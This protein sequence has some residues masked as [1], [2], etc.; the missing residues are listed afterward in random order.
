MIVNHIPCGPFV[1]ESERLA[2]EK[3]FSK[4]QSTSGNLQYIILTNLLFS[5][6]SKGQ[7]DEIDMIILYPSGI[8]VIEIKHWDGKYIVRNIHTVEHEAERLNNKVKKIAG[9]LKRHS[10]DVG[11]IEGKMLLT[12]GDV[13]K[14]KVIRGVGLYSLKNLI[15]FLKKSSAPLYDDATLKKVCHILEPKTKVTISGD[16]RSFGQI[17]NLELMSP[18]KERFHRVYKGEHITRKDKVILHIYDLSAIDAPMAEDIARRE[19]DVIQR[20]QKLPQL[21]RIMDSFQD[22]TGY[23]GELYFYSL[24]DPSAPTLREIAKDK[25]ILSKERLSIALNCLER[26]NE[27]HNPIEEEGQFV[28]HRRLNPDNIK[29]KN[30]QNPIFTDFTYAK[31]PDSTISPFLDEKFKEDEYM[32][33]ELKSNGIF[34]ATPLSDTYSLCKCLCLLFEDADN[35]LDILKKGLT[36]NPSNRLALESIINELKKLSTPSTYDVSKKTTLPVNL[37][38]EDTIIEFRGNNYK[39]VNKLGS[40]GMGTTFKVVQINIEDNS[41]IGSFVAKVIHNESD[42]KKAIEAYNKIRPHINPPNLSLIFEVANQ[43]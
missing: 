40:G 7:S 8:V 1:T 10:I 4:I 36:D 14:D 17:R 30:R 24:I 35:I 6:D 5:F 18:P 32:A 38:D 37:W 22:A 26:L 20:L 12:K 28:I 21:P 2:F 23:P 9:L 33:P 31:L 19:F 29:I 27:L 41:E 43:W 13:P 16:I 34:H 39:I 42:G 25:N 3:I 11:F 15:E